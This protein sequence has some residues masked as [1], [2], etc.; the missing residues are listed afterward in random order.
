MG[1]MGRTGGAVLAGAVLGLAATAL[2]LTEPLRAESSPILPRRVI[3]ELA[4]E[5]SLVAYL[6][7][8]PGAGKSKDETPSAVILYSGEAGWGPLPQETASHLASEGRHVLG[9]ASPDYFKK[10]IEAP[11]LIADLRSFRAFVNRSARRQEG[12]PVILAGFAFGAEMIPYVLSRAEAGGVRGLLLIAPDTKGAK[13]YSAAARLGMEAPTDETFDVAEEIRRLPPL[14][15]VLMQGALDLEGEA[16]SLLPLFRGPKVFLSIPEG[17]HFLRKARGPY[18]GQVS[19]ALRFIENPEKAPL[20]DK[21][22]P[23]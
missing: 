17:D 11:G 13:V 23:P 9:I 4:S 15:V 22:S 16:Q 20:E 21:P 18:L 2:P 3:L 12:A 19:A 7:E 1:R 5:E 8:P 6:Y 10:R 14:P